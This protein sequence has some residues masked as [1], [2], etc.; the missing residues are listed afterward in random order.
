MRSSGARAIPTGSELRFAAPV[1]TDT[2][3]MCFVAKVSPQ[4]TAC[5]VNSISMGF[6]KVPLAEAFF[7]GAWGVE[8]L[9]ETCPAFSLRSQ[10]TWGA[11]LKTS[12]E[13]IC[14]GKTGHAEA[15]RVRVLPR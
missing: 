15:V 12:Y 2:S 13:A 8:H 1:V 5:C 7:A 9:L 10:A 11:H 3:G 14:T 4:A 6:N